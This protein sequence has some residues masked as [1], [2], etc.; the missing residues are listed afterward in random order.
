MATEKFIKLGLIEGTCDVAILNS[1]S[2]LKKAGKNAA[3][4]I[5]LYYCD[6]DRRIIGNDEYWETTQKYSCSSFILPSEHPTG[7]FFVPAEFI[8]HDRNDCESLTFWVIRPDSV[9][10]LPLGTYDH[11]TYQLVTIPLNVSECNAP[12]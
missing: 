12:Q 4:R 8:M 11:Y 5:R 10:T 2:E 1:V 7:S 3:R 9:A 6:E